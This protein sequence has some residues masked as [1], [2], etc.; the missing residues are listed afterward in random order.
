MARLSRFCVFWIRKTMRN[1]TIVVPVLMTNCHVSLKPKTGPVPAQTTIT[2][3]ATR[4]ATGRP[5]TRAVHLAKRVNQDLDL[6]G[7]IVVLPCPEEE[8]HRSSS[9]VL[10]AVVDR[11]LH[12][13]TPLRARTHRVETLVNLPPVRAG[14]PTRGH[15]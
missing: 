12:S 6:V 2:V 10:A 11:L 3:T 8:S 1:V 7:R 4:N 15:S 14:G 5:V 13:S 9:S